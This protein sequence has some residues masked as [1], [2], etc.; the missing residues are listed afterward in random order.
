MSESVRVNLGDGSA[1]GQPLTIDP[2]VTPDSVGS[3]RS[4]RSK[5]WMHFIV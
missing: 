4:K 2:D 3:K 1:A 5:A